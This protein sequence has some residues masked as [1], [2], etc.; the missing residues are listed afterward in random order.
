MASGSSTS[1]FGTKPSGGRGG[2]E[3]DSES[4]SSAAMGGGSNSGG[5]GMTGKMSG[6][7]ISIGNSWNGNGRPGW[8]GEEIVNVLRQDGIQGKSVVGDTECPK[9][10]MPIFFPCGDIADGEGKIDG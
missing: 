9:Y 3:S 5:G 7:S 2:A 1:K 6:S 4:N 8:E 10:G